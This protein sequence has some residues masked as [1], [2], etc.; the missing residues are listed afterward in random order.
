MS[1]DLS[2]VIPHRGNPLGIWSTVHSCY[3]D[4]ITTPLTFEFVIVTNGEEVPVET[5]KFLKTLDQ[6][7]G[8]V[9]HIHSKEPLAPPV[10]RQRG[11]AQADG[12]LLCFVDNHVILDRHFFDRAVLD[13]EHFGCDMLHSTT[14]FYA[15]NIRNYEYKLK[16]DYNFWGESATVPY[17][18]YKP[19]QIAAGGHG[20]FF[21]RKS[22]WDEVGGYGPESL[23]DGYG[24]EELLFD[25]KM[26][27]YGKNNFI[28]PKVLHYH[29][30]GDRGYTRHFSDRYYINL[31]VSAH[32]IGGEKWLY[33]LFDSFINKSHLRIS[34]RKHMY[35]ILEA[36]YNRSAEYAR[37][38]DSKSKYTLDEL[39]I[40]FRAEQVRM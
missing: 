30:T 31:L 27:R 32:V 18:D 20:G 19:Y 5:E 33:K 22:V 14:C 16:L 23:F 9:K 15:G 36:A 8:L 21:V 25:L 6:T 28:D 37:E 11:A 13:I 17:S 3:Q 10:A 39:L 29:Y 12:R 7:K 38:V 24:G 34:P 4:L 35:D 1:L 40:K 26:W 2:I